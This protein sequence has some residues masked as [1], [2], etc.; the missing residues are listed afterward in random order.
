VTTPS[1]AVP[2]SFTL[3]HH[4]TDV[5]LMRSDANSSSSLGMPSHVRMWRPPLEPE[6]AG[7]TRDTCTPSHAAFSDTNLSNR[8]TLEHVSKLLTPF[9]ALITPFYKS[10]SSTSSPWQQPNGSTKANLHGKEFI[11]VRKCLA[12]NQSCR[13]SELPSLGRSV[14]DSPAAA[15]RLVK[16]VNR[17]LRAA[18][19]RRSS[20]IARTELRLGVAHNQGAT[21]RAV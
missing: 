14:P 1:S 19:R 13:L 20:R 15:S 10:L 18:S 21:Y 5:C 16:G 6:R 7:V 11:P 4:F 3:F 12:F 2:V 17:K 9:T 8:R